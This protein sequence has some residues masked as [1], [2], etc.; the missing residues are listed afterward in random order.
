MKLAFLTFKDPRLPKIDSDGGAVT[1][2][3]YALGLARLGHSV[4]IFTPKIIYPASDNSYLSRKANAQIGLQ[5]KLSEGVKVHGRE[6]AHV[7]RAQLVQGDLNDLPSIVDSYFFAEALSDDRL[8]D[9][10]FVSIFHPIAG[11]GVINRGLTDLK[12]TV[13]FPMLLSDYYARYQHVSQ[14]YKDSELNILKKVGN[15]FSPSID[16]ANASIRKGISPQKIKVVHRGVDVDNFFPEI[17]Q[18]GIDVYRGVTITCTNA[19]RPQKGQHHLVLAARLLKQEGMKVTI[20]LAGENKNFYKP[21]DAEYYRKLSHLAR[22]NGMVEEVNFLGPV[23]PKEVSRIL[24]ESDL[25]VFPSE[26]ESFGK[27]PLEAMISGTPTI[28][29]SDVPA[30]SEFVEPGIN[31]LPI[32]RTPASIAK[33]IISL[34]MD[35]DLYL[36]F[37]RA[38]TKLLGK[39]NWEKVSADLE[40]LYIEIAGNY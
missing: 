3:N 27:A 15:I 19:I 18:E 31:A 17:K 37:S 34:S 23:P 20:N 26:A 28:V 35:D 7:D 11:F 36:Q 32:V 1:V 12:R 5:G 33:A 2:R 40:K 8:K 16:E 6:M 9:Y 13:L 25:A 24:R 22:E 21:E 29:G 30:Y 38:S 14:M 4:D 10:D 39:F